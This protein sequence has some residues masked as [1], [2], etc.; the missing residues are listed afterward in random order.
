MSKSIVLS[1][2]VS[3]AAVAIGIAAT[4]TWGGELPT[5]LM[6]VTLSL[7]MLLAMAYGFA[8]ALPRFDW[9][10]SRPVRGAALVC[11]GVAAVFIPLSFVIA[12]LCIGHGT[13]L[14][15]AAACEAADSPPVVARVV[16][17]GSGVVRAGHQEW[18]VEHVR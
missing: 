11:L 4:L 7:T 8:G 14:V 18:E 5:W 6:T 15:W 2:G 17:T 3:F 12:A 13:K 9:L 10:N 1:C 16:P